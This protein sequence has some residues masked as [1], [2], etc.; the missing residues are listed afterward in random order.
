MAK[1]VA[2]MVAAEGIEQI[3]L[4]SPWQAVKESGAEPELVSSKSGQVQAYHAYDR[5]DRFKVDRVLAEVSADN[6]AGLV[7]PGGVGNPDELRLNT[8]ALKLVRAMLDAGKPVAAICHAGW[9]LA[10]ADV[11]AGRRVTSWR[12]VRTDLVNAGADWVS[13]DVVVD[14]NGPGILITSRDPNDLKSFNS[15][16]VANI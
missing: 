13:Q 7:L 9:V 8:D 3:E 15:A 4:T 14:R 16:I 12:S 5:G 11:V 2:F 6:Y 10:E 1:K